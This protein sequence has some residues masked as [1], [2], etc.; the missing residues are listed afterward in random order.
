[1]ES[2]FFNKKAT[3]LQNKIT[4][5]FYKQLFHMPHQAV[6]QSYISKRFK[7]KINI[8]NVLKSIITT[9]SLHH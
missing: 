2:Y 8:A 7:R 1:M 3:F 9:K 4:L 5:F 6:Q